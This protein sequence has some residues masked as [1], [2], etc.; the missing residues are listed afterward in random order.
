MSAFTDCVKWALEKSQ[1]SGDRSLSGFL[2]K[3]VRI[4]S[5]TPE[6]NNKY[7][8][9]KNTSTILKISYLNITNFGIKKETQ[10]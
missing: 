3:Q 7:I 2:G 9:V 6:I 10:Q 4:H 5:F 1:A 8:Q